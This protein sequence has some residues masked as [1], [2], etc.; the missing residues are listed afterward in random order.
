MLTVEQVWKIGNF[1]ARI[2]KEVALEL[3][4]SWPIPYVLPNGS[5]GFLFFYYASFGPPPAEEQ[6]LY[7]P[8]WL[9][10][11]GRENGS[12]EALNRIEPAEVDLYVPKGVPFAVHRWSPNVTLVETEKKR[13]TFLKEYEQVVTIWETASFKELPIGHP[14]IDSFREYFLQFT[15]PPYFPCYRKLSPVFFSWLT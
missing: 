14:V 1:S 3:L 15:E 12:V 7:P 2:R 11:I 9:A 5:I 10:R 4:A 6:Q 13:V 8:S